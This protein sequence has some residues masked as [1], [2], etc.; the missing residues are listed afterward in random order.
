MVKCVGGGVTDASGLTMGVLEL[1]EAV[2]M[3]VLE[4]VEGVAVD[5]LE[6]VEEVSKIKLRDTCSVAGDLIS[7]LFE[8]LGG[9][10]FA[11]GDEST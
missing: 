6:L 3:N 8:F 5:V 2:A 7:C 4:L 9:V 1:V 10:L 11:T